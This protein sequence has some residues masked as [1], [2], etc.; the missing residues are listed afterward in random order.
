MPHGNSHKNNN[1]HHLYEITDTLEDEV[2][3]YG[4]SDDEIEEDGLSAR[5][6]DQLSLFNLVAN[7]LR[8]VGKILI[9]DIPGRKTAEQIEEEHV[10]QHVAKYGKRPRGNR[11]KKGRK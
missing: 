9:I 6:R 1:L 7:F 10:Q 4:V 3:K 5:L 8:F 2:Y 11:E